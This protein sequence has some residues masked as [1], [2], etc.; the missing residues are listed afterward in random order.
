[1][2]PP[3]PS[4]TQGPRQPSKQ[5]QQAA[6]P[7]VI[8]SE[9][10]SAADA[11][12]RTSSLAPDATLPAAVPKLA[13]A[14]NLSAQRSADAPVQPAVA[15]QPA[16]TPSTLSAP[17]A[18]PVAAAA[19]A[20]AAPSSSAAQ[21][22]ALSTAAANPLPPGVAAATTSSLLAQP[23]AAAKPAATSFQQ[24]ATSIPSASAE[25]VPAA[26]APEP[27]SVSTAQPPAP[28]PRPVPV[29][30]PLQSEP[31]PSLPLAPDHPAQ[32]QASIPAE[33]H[34]PATQ[35]SRSRS[36]T[37]VESAASLSA[38]DA[39]RQHVVGKGAS[40]H[41]APLA[42]PAEAAASR[43]SVSAGPS[44]SS[45]AV[46]MSHRDP[47][48]LQAAAASA[49]GGPSNASKAPAAQSAPTGL[50]GQAEQ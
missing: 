21:T 16:L 37:A 22:A 15:S 17:A 33:A 31:T 40:Q 5:Q 39:G 3:A 44:P 30:E 27:A 50:T 13:S 45:A 20:A 11:A 9:P 23:S 34:R 38:L 49:A 24:D 7:P 32:S 14:S 10:S 6:Q 43:H 47:R 8:K 25:A 36:T 4:Q 12:D 48:R 29:P 19:A 42:M 1:M 18:A 46:G 26:S 41:P 35:P 2:S 28:T